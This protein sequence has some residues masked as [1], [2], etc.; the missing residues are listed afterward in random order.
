[1]IEGGVHASNELDFQ[2]FMVVCS[3]KKASEIYQDLRKKMGKKVND[4]GGFNPPFKNPE[5]VLKLLSQYKVKIIIDAA[6]S[7]FYQ[8]GKYQL[9]N[10]TFNKK[11]LLSY[12]FELIKKY[13]ILG[14]EDPFAEDNWDGWK[15]I[16]S[17]V[18]SQKS[19]VLVIGD[20]LLV[21]NPERMKMAN[22][23]NACNAIIIKPNQIGTITKTIEAVK[24]AKSYG[25]KIIVS[26]RAGETCDDFISDFAVGVGADFIKAGAPARGERVVT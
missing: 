10:G 20:D 6:A 16:M 17:K 1:M 13:P 19:K 11:S 2:E 5:D 18:Q 9:K 7:Q 15:A 12:Y 4:E 24:L 14:I 3:I 25:W 22:E 23:R 26:H 8:N 21:T